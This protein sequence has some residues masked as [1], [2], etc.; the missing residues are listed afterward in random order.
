M[1]R[2]VSTYRTAPMWTNAYALELS[3]GMKTAE[4][5]HDIIDAEYEDVTDTVKKGKA[6]NANKGTININDAPTVADPVQP[7]DQPTDQGSNQNQ[8]GNNA[9]KA[10]GPSF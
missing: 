5:I 2:R 7:E 3:M 9:S 8:P 1:T 10:N 4:K 6:E